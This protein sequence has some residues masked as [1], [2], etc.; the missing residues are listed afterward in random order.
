MKTAELTVKTRTATGNGPAR[1]LRRE[2][3]FPAVL[4]GPGSDNV[5]LVV[6]R[7]EFDT[8]LKKAGTEQVLF[9][10]QVEGQGA[11]RRLALVKEIQRDPLS[12]KYLHADF[13]EVFMDRPITVT[14]PVRMAGKAKGLDF[15]G[16]LQIIR[17]ELTVTALP[18][19][20]PDAIEVDVTGLNVGDALHL[21]DITPPEGVR[22]MGAA[23]YT[24]VTVVSPTG[25]KAPE[26]A[27]EGEAEEE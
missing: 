8:I 27:A 15:G 16:L 6:D 3:A 22:L 12:R 14:V 17:R 2:G 18:G 9:N 21:G 5:L 10:L 4:Y 24:V 13:Y 20:V 11:A 25:E 19:A 26:A 23:Q 1:V 7:K